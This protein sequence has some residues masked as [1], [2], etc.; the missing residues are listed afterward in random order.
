MKND[1]INFSRTPTKKKFGPLKI[2]II[3]AI[4][5][6]IVLVLVLSFMLTPML[7]SGDSMSTTLEDGEM[8]F[9]SRIFTSINVDDV[10]IYKRVDTDY[11]VVKRVVGVEGDKFNLVKH[12]DSLGYASFS[13]E[14]VTASEEKVSFPLLSDQYLFLT[15][16]YT[17]HSFTVG[18]DELFTIGDNYEC[19]MDG[20]NYGCIST[21]QVKGIVL[22]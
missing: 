19:S 21:D 9:V 3:V 11:T 17:E 13:L 18:A 10:I 8:I 2:T 22:L 15:A 4:F 6:A 16:L 1:Q 7:V 12:T 14:K 5:V 20:R